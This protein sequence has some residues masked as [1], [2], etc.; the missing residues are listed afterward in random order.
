MERRAL[1]KRKS[2]QPAMT[3]TQS[4]G[5]MRTGLQRLRT[6]AKR[7]SHLV[8]NNLL[9]HL[10][11]ERLKQAYYSLNR[12]SAKGIDEVSWTDYGQAL[13]SNLSELHNRIHSGRY[14][15]EA[16]KRVWIPKD[17]GEKRPLGI[18]S[19]EDKLVQQALVWI[20]ES[21]YEEDFLGFSYGFRPKRS[22]HDALD[23]IHIAITQKK[24]SWVLDADIKG[25]FDHIDQEWLMQ[26][27]SH[28]ISDKRVL[29][30]L[31]RILRAGV[32]EDGKR[33]RTRA[34][35]PQGA[36]I[37]PLLA[38]IYLHYVLDLWINQWRRKEA[39]GEVYIVRYAD[40]FVIG[41]QYKDDGER[42][43]LALKKRMEQFGLTLHEGKTR[44]IEFGR[45]A[46]DNRQK[47]KQGKPETFDFLGFTHICSTKRSDNHFTVKRQTIKKRQRAKLKAVKQ[48]LYA[49]RC[50]NV[51]LQGKWLK[52]VITGFNNYYAVPGNM[53][54][55]QLFRTEICKSW[56][57]SLRRRG[58]KRPI[59]WRNTT[60][61]IRQWIPSVRIVHP[62]PLQRWSV[63]YSR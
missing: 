59:N 8:F 24:V 62:Y 21:I 30:L 31:S 14:K 46:A 43:H 23:A 40:D 50:L 28:R 10:T 45:F 63:K 38:N 58:N 54:S 26:F 13:E 17:N 7:D 48:Q 5:E 60:S 57:K 3:L 44:L 35:T 32:V 39:R 37:S 55:L 61:L 2:L 53:E 33:S 15:P 9:H 18:T 34:G 16:I 56:R 42:L 6:A 52:Q 11:V 20:M 41:F 36:V 1:T 29:E 12:Q 51:H 47:R 27:I 4:K 25:F 49:I 19:L 22:A